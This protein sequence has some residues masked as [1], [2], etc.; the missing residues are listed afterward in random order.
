M[1]IV[2]NEA[3]RYFGPTGEGGR[4]FATDP[5]RWPILIR[6]ARNTVPTE[7]VKIEWICEGS[8][9]CPTCNHPTGH[10]KI[11]HNFTQIFRT[12]VGT[13][14]NALEALARHFDAI[15][16]A[17]QRGMREFSAVGSAPFSLMGGVQVLLGRWP[18]KGDYLALEVL[19]TPHLLIDEVDPYGVPRDCPRKEWISEVSLM[20]RKG[21]DD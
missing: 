12:K 8:Q 15:E 13:D 2:A 18:R 1:T 4:V 9:R 17:M 16:V 14:E 6:A 11:D 7:R 20:A 10:A 21:H 19:R 5:D 3:A